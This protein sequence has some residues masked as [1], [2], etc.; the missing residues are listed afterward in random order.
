[1]TIKIAI[2]GP[3]GSGKSTV[4]KILAKK[5]NFVYVDTGALY[6]AITYKIL[7]E[8]ININEKKAILNIINNF[9]ITL[10]SER[11]FLDGIDI[12]E[13]IRKPY[14]SQNVSQISQIPE[15]REFMVKLQKELA[16]KNNIVMDGRDITTVVMPDAQFK[17]Y[18]TA[19]EEVRAK[20]RYNELKA[21]NFN[22]SFKDILNEIKIRDKMDMERSI[23][24]LKIAEDAIVVDTSDMTI[25]E[26]TNKLY[27]II[28]K[29]L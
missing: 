27:D 21:N 7:K 3:A 25:D 1:M 12:T 20:R 13:E 29:Q 23:A 18:I 8:G 9:D 17:F 15:I 6:R 16:N 10:K 24:P 22:I 2:D 5:L 11:I 19:T 4:A 28:I 14:I 26:V